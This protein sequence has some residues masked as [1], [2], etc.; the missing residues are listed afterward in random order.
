MLKKFSKKTWGIFTA[1]NRTPSLTEHIRPHQ[2][3]AQISSREISLHTEIIGLNLI[4]Y[5][6]CYKHHITPTHGITPTATKWHTKAW[7][8]ELQ[9]QEVI[10]AFTYRG[11]WENLPKGE[12]IH[13]SIQCYDHLRQLLL[14]VTVCL[15]SK[16]FGFLSLLTCTRLIWNVC[17]IDP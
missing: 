12:N 7:N 17:P 13:H 10:E 4:F 16:C 1:T 6:L 15:T 5:F 11:K 3:Y 8:P 14:L 2:G 9:K